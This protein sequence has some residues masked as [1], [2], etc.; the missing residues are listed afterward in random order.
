MSRP[1][2]LALS[3]ASLGAISSCLADE[4]ERTKQIRI[5]VERIDRAL[6]TLRQNPTDIQLRLEVAQ[7]CLE[8][9][10]M[11]HLDAAGENVVHLARD[12]VHEILGQ[13]PSHEVARKLCLLLEDHDLALPAGSALE[14]AGKAFV[15]GR[16]EDAIRLANEVRNGGDAGP[17][18]PAILGA[19]YTLLWEFEDARLFLGKAIEKDRSC[20]LALRYRAKCDER[21][22]QL[23]EAIDGYLAAIVED[24]GLDA[25][26]QDLAWAV[27]HR[28]KRVARVRIAQIADLREDAEGKLSIVLGREEKDERTN[29]WLG[30]AA[31]RAKWRKTEFQAKYGKGV[32]YRR[33]LAEEMAAWEKALEI[34]RHYRAENAALADPDLDR[35]EALRGRGLLAAHVWVEKGQPGFAGALDA[36][37][38]VERAAIERYL[39]EVV[40]VEPGH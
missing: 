24:P 7:T 10:A 22:R 28:G 33:T 35:L 34:W 40:L 1:T 15:E 5:R 8:L 31:T 18:P 25:A 13:E 21:E 39:R 27:R 4:E 38:G 2:L 26:W 12:Q 30:Y 3:L 17:L 32:A 19:A 9:S 29:A 36:A 20:A 14:P 23:D 11:D 16:L 6:E 37:G